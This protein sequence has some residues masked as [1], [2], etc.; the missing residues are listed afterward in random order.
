MILALG[1]AGS[2]CA[3]EAVAIAAAA[4]LTYV[5]DALNT[6][7]RAAAPDTDV[8]VSLGASGNLFA[9][10]QNG[11]PFDLFLSADAEFAGRLAKAGFADARTLQPFAVGQLALWT[12]REHLELTDIAALVRNPEVKK[13]ALAQPKTA[14]Y[15][16]AAEAALRSLHAWAE[17]QPKLVMGENISQAAQF[18]AS[19]NA[20]AGFV[21]LSLIATPR[22]P[23]AGRWVIVSPSLYPGVALDHVAVLTTHGGENDAA[24]RYLVFLRSAAAQKILRAYGYGVPAAAPSTP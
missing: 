10:I 1:S 6:A 5:L 11:A 20:D 2:A 4:N 19:G 24:R 15:G 7:Y 18:V 8:R 22:K 23:A 21:A 14:P 9:Q 3:R 17:V 12:T 16:Q 13:L